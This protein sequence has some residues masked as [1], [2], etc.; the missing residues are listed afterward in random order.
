MGDGG[1]KG[2]DSKIES[3]LVDAALTTLV[4]DSLRFESNSCKARRCCI[5]NAPPPGEFGDVDSFWRTDDTS[6]A[7]V[8][9]YGVRGVVRAALTGVSGFAVEGAER[10]LPTCMRVASPMLAVMTD[11]AWVLKLSGLDFELEAQGREGSS[12]FHSGSGDDVVCVECWLGVWIGVPN[13]LAEG[14][15]EP[16]EVCEPVTYGECSSPNGSCFASSSW[17]LS[18]SVSTS[19]SAGPKL[20]AARGDRIG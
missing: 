13:V 8:I 9:L 1:T 11:P 10:M 19:I 5:S 6:L 17:T 15:G 20:E 18:S 7:L 16:G 14:V 2:N 4:R 3:A 12:G